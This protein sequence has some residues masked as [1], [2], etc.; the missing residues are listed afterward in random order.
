[1]RNWISEAWISEDSLLQLCSVSCFHLTWMCLNDV[2]LAGMTLTYKVHAFSGLACGW[3]AVVHRLLC[4]NWLK[5]VHI[6][7]HDSYSLR[8]S[9]A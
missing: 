8:A 7:M 6:I 5:L 3:I 9:D 1:M 4:M 2:K